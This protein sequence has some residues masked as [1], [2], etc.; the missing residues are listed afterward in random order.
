MLSPPGRKHAIDPNEHAY[1]LLRESMPPGS[2]CACNRIEAQLQIHLLAKNGF[3]TG[4]RRLA[5]ATKKPST[6]A[7]TRV[8]PADEVS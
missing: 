3:L 2:I 7:E 1:P 5:R 4:A 6:K 8:R